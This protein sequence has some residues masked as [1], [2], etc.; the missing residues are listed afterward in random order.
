MELGF[1]P[2]EIEKKEGGGGIPISCLRTGVRKF[3][4]TTVE[5]GEVSVEASPKRT[6]TLGRGGAP[7]E[8]HPQEGRRLKADRERC[9]KG[10]RGEGG[11]RCRHKEENGKR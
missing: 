3:P 11:D 9:A 5:R 1:P 6:S 10:G 7:E 2:T 8:I 4:M